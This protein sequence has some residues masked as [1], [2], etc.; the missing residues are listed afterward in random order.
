M[1]VEEL[2]AKSPVDEI[3][4]TIAEKDEPRDVRGGQLKV[5]DCVAKDDTGSI[6]LTL[7]NE[8]IDKVDAGD[9]VTITKGWVNEFQGKKQLSKG[10]FGE[11]EIKKGE[12]PKEEEKPKEVLDAVEEDII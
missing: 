3:T 4:L 5:C 2:V 10:R 11:M 9:T 8:D 6:S 1:K 12:A 7:W